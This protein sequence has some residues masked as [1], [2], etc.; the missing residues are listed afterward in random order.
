M[1][2]RNISF[3]VDMR[4][5]PDVQTVGIRGGAEPLDWNESVFMTDEDG[6]S[7]YTATVLFTTPYKN[8][9]MKFVLNEAIFEL[10]GKNNRDVR[11]SE[12]GMTEFKAIF[13]KEL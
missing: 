12:S 13:D 1:K 7:I 8:V 5:V 10:E 3:S 4:G 9:N 6:D 2:E 11:F